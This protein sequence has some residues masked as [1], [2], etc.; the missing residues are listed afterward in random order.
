[1]AHIIEYKRT[2]CDYLTPCKHFKNINVGEY[3]CCEECKF[4]DGWEEDPSPKFK[5]GDYSRYSYIH[6]G[7]VK[8]KKNA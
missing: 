1:M 8:C 6:T 7:R 3:E 5:V 2:W 4:N